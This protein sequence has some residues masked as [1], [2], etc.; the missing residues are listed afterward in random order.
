LA[1]YEEDLKQLSDDEP[2]PVR[3]RRRQLLT[4]D[5]TTAA[6]GKLLQNNPRGLLLALDE[7]SAWVMRMNQYTAGK[8][9]DL[10]FYLSLW[11]GA[12]L[13]VNRKKEDELI[14]VLNPLG[15]V[16]GPIPPAVLGELNDERGREDGFVH[17]I[18]FAYPE[19][20]PLAWS[21]EE[22]DGQTSQHY[23]DF[24]EKLFKLPAA[25]DQG[26]D[27]PV[28]LP[29]CTE[30]RD[31]FGQFVTQL[32]ADMQAEEFPDALRGPWAKL[33][34]YAARLA[35]ILQVCW[36]AASN[37]TS[38][39][40]DVQSVERAITLVDYFKSH[41]RRVYPCLRSGFSDKRGRD[42][43]AVLD[44]IKKNRAKI[45]AKSPPHFTWRNIRHDLRARF[46]GQEKDLQGALKFLESRDYLKEVSRGGSGGRL[47]KS[48][49]HV[50]PAVW[51]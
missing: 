12:P 7:L 14:C 9:D 39:Q 26:Q 42:A 35:L 20:M 11:N 29:L 28:T 3:P 16:V 31:K 21:D 17:R 24:M 6:L 10:Q 43:N 1:K 47:P 38:T 49:Y 40:V 4:T 22:I 13:L 23:A 48:D 36:D 37:L 45:E 46:A 15:N 33:D 41:A 2:K 30:A 50:N 8:G 19:P 34:G 5:S 51:N 27:I 44:W 25:Q 32:G 18:L